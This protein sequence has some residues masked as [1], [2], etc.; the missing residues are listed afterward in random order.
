MSQL[1]LPRI[2]AWTVGLVLWAGASA[3]G[4]SSGE[5]VVRVTPRQEERVHDPLLAA[6]LAEGL[7]SDST[8]ALLAD[9]V[10]LPTIAGDDAAREAFG[11]RLRKAAVAV[12]LTFERA[13]DGHAF[14]IGLPPGRAFKPVYWIVAH[15]DVVPAERSAWPVPPFTLTA[16]ADTLYGRGT[17]DDKGAVSASLYAMAALQRTG[18]YLYREPRLVI[19]MHEET[20]WSGIDALLKEREAPDFAIVVDADFPVTVGERGYIELAVAAVSDARE[21]WP[22]LL[23]FSGGTAANV[24]AA[25]ATLL[26]QAAPSAGSR[27]EQMLRERARLPGELGADISLEIQRTADRIRLKAVGRAAHGSTPEE[28]RNAILPLLRFG[29]AVGAF[30][31]AQAKLV[32][33]IRERLGGQSNGAGLG[34]AS[35]VECLGAT[36]VNLGT[37]KLAD[38]VLTLVL[39]V[40]PTTEWDTAEVIRRIESALVVDPGITTRSVGGPGF[41]AFLTQPR[42]ALVDALS[43]AYREET[44]RAAEPGCIGGT[45]YAKAFLGT[46]TQAVS[47]GPAE[48]ALGEDAVYHADPEYIL[49]G[50]LNRNIRIYTQALFRLSSRPDLNTAAVA[51]ERT[52]EP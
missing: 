9:L 33:A 12:G 18:A 23:A 43:A 37:A 5:S 1:I 50:T 19:G 51:T 24:V 48:P 47:F 16:R 13:V 44:D 21:A 49:A 40:R 30:H 7:Y 22:R 42:S 14:V 10:A 6:D 17:L 4:S 15:G 38:G 11:Q 28:G 25:R 29:N 3:A 31:G 27:L 36:T 2:L 8:R 20:D 52:P 45:T 39:N 41:D 34:I 32:S 46:K 26:L 35:E